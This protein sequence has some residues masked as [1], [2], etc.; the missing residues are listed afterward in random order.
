[1]SWNCTVLHNSTDTLTEQTSLNSNLLVTFGTNDWTSKVMQ[2][3]ENKHRD[4][5]LRYITKRMFL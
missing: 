1:M 2:L 4:I 5:K 3:A